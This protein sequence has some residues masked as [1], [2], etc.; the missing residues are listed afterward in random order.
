[1]K[2][3]TCI[4]FLILVL[5]SG[6]Q[7]QSSAILDSLQEVVQADIPVHQK[8]DAYLQMARVSGEVDTTQR[9][10]YQQQAME[11]LTSG[12]LD[13]ENLYRHLQFAQKWMKEGNYEA[14]ILYLSRVEQLCEQANDQK[15][16]GI[17][18]LLM[19][20]LN[21]HQLDTEAAIASYFKGLE[22]FQN[23][24]DVKGQINALNGLSSMYFSSSQYVKAM[25]Y[26]TQ[27]LE[28]SEVLDPAKPSASALSLLGIIHDV[29]GE[30]A[31]ALNYLLRAEKVYEGT[32]DISALASALSNIGKCYRDLGEY[33][34]SLEYYERSL[35]LF[36]KAGYLIGQVKLSSS[37]GTLHEM[38]DHD[39]QAIYYFEKAEKI[40]QI[41]GGENDNYSLLTGFGK[42]Y[43]KRGQTDL[44]RQYFTRALT[45]AEEKDNFHDGSIAADQ[46][47]QLEAAQGNYQEALTA[48][49]TYKEMSDSL[50]DKNNTKRILLAEANYSFAKEKDSLQFANEKEKLVLNQEIQ[51]QHSIQYGS[52]VGIL[53]LLTIIYILYRFYTAKQKANLQLQQQRDEIEAQKQALESLDRTK[54]R[55]FAN[56]S[57]ELRTPL[58]LA[59][60]PLEELIQGQTD[61]LPEAVIQKIALAKQNTYKLKHLVDD[62][63][64]LT[65]LDARKIGLSPSEVPMQGFISRIFG[66]FRSMAQYRGLDYALDLG[67]L[68]DDHQ[69]VDADKLEKVLNNLLSNALKYS[70]TGGKVKLSAQKEG[71]HLKIQVSDT[72]SGISAEDLPYIF[73]RYFQSKQPDAPIQG[74]TGIG[75]AMAKEYVQLMG[76]KITVES[77]V[78]VGS[79]FTVTLPYKKVIPVKEVSQ[80]LVAPSLEEQ[81]LL[82]VPLP[83]TQK[84]VLIVEDQPDMLHY[85]QALL[86]KSYT[87]STAMNGK[88]ALAV[89]AQQPIDLI[90]SDVMM[91]EMDGF[92]LLKSIRAHEVYASIPVIMLT[93]LSDEAYKL[94]ALTLGVDDYLPKP[95]STAELMARTQNML[96]RYEVRQHTAKELEELP[97]AQMEQDDTSLP[98]DPRLTERGKAFVQRVE[99]VIQAEMENEDFSLIQ[100]ADQ[101]CLSYSQFSRRLKLLTGLSPKQ[102][103]QE[104]ALQKAR[105]L[106]E[107][108]QY[109]SV[110]AVAHSVGIS[111][112]TRFSKMY[113]KRFG[114]NPAAYFEGFI[115]K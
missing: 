112:V 9:Q 65:K 83:S 55:F 59:Y 31:Q 23:I 2:Y 97:T 18:Y 46:L 40:T 87:V 111:H 60:A 6:V 12:Q 27:A 54:S 16:K 11:L 47:Y 32:P 103:Q 98:L 35:E 68:P 14:A 39:D 89:L 10:H 108:R 70:S 66:T 52:L 109:A 44:A 78:G 79:T 61:A 69:R 113:E 20:R 25:E 41:L 7:A 1:M 4:I 82:P 80:T 110:S 43:K 3:L 84:H 92:E 37:I 74:G 104:V 56:V 38:L 15:R 67:A 91:P 62:I 17:V 105:R 33:E 99:A 5:Y 90:V 34:K 51:T 94:E 53:L 86:Q 72:G 106:L 50:R 13:T 81:I 73:D 115:K 8:V 45:K 28:A 57:H 107:S 63:L 42:I 29:I 71:E 26:A 75:L 58:T 36:E 101:F 22:I 76:G 19:G 95:F 64:N 21:Y 48:Y 114:K 102:F 77:K 96:A 49:L 93:A 88:E 100:L 30:S 85:I 24:Q